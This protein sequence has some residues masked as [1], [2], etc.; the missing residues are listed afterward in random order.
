MI[1]YPGNIS[2]T[3]GATYLALVLKAIRLLLNLPSF[4]GFS[5][6]VRD[7]CKIDF[8]LVGIQATQLWQ[9]DTGEIPKLLQQYLK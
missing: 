6:D 4:F 5:L 9:K 1:A 8:K 2:V 3:R 7:S